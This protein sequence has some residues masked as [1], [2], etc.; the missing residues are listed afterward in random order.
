MSVT[1]QEV[2]LPKQRSDECGR[3]LHRHDVSARV[4]W[5]ESASSL[6]GNTQR[7]ELAA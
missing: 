6:V 3:R 1:V 4:P 2:L 7:S 5:L